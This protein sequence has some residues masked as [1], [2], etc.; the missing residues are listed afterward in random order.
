MIEVIWD[1]TAGD[2]HSGPD[3]KECG[4]QPASPIQ[5][6][7]IAT[8]PKHLSPQPQGFTMLAKGLACLPDTSTLSPET[9]NTI[10]E[11]ARSTM[12]L[13]L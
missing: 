2:V 10:G 4:F 1:P 3:V 6:Q 8:L 9:G 5:E 11:E 13:S 12:T 7:V